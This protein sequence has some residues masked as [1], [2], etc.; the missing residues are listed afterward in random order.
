MFTTYRITIRC[1]LQSIACQ[2]LYPLTEY[3]LALGPLPQN[4]AARLKAQ[5]NRS[6]DMLRLFTNPSPS[7]AITGGLYPLEDGSRLWI[8]NGTPHACCTAFFLSHSLKFLSHFL[9]NFSEQASSIRSTKARSTITRGNRFII[10]IQNAKGRNLCFVLS[11]IHWTRP[12]L[13]FRT[14]LQLNKC[15][16]PI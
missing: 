6:A 10:A 1:V 12:T 11:T 4:T 9:N 7:S 3:N 13:Y 14:A 2:C 16:Q 5:W 15:T 8:W